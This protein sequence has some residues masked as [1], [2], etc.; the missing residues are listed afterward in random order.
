M[1][2]MILAAGEGR[3]MRPLTENV[4][5]PLLEVAGRPLIEHHLLRLSAAGYQ[6]VVVNVS[7][8]GDQLRAFLGNGDRWGLKIQ[9][10]AELAPLET[11]GGII[12]ALPLLGK[13]PF[14]LVNSDIYTDY[15]FEK[16][17]NTRLPVRGAHLV[18]VPNPPHH[19]KGDFLLEGNR[20]IGSDNESS[21]KIELSTLRHVTYAGIARFD[22]IFFS[23]VRPGRRPLRPLLDRAIIEELVSGELFEGMWVDVGT[24]ER[25]EACNHLFPKG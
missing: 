24:P 9:I 13:E 8:F 7:Y 20:C 15:P 5:K 21:G 12:Q 6:E 10:S 22:P 16:L 17:R 23:R 14:L 2:A 3:R 19:P 4:P 11:A 18:M 25:L 1:K